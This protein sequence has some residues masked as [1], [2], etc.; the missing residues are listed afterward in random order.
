L[1]QKAIKK[2]LHSSFDI[3]RQSPIKVFWLLSFSKESKRTFNCYVIA[4]RILFLL[5]LHNG[6]GLI[7]PDRLRQNLFPYTEFRD[8]SSVALYIFLGKVVKQTAAA[9][10]HLQQTELTMLVFFMDFKM[11]CKLPYAL[12]EDCDLHLRGACVGPVCAIAFDYCV[13][14]IFRYHI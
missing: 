14:L 7:R 12:C 2:N 4:L 3:C 10:D 8:T 6:A 1:K 13:F 5:V 11:F 9:A